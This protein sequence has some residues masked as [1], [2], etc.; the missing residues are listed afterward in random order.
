MILLSVVSY[1]TRAPLENTTQ[2]QSSLV[3]QIT[4][5]SNGDKK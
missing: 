4:G 2:C 3:L 5:T 1:S